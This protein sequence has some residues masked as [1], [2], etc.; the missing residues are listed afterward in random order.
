MI[1]K[2]DNQAIDYI[3]KNLEVSKE[4]KII[5]E[6]SKELRALVNG[7]NFIDELI[8]KIEGIESETKAKQEKNTAVIFKIYLSVYFNQFL[9]F[10]MLLWGLRNMI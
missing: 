8:C 4:F 10:I 2:D 7:E 1:F 6:N 5:R 9:I 3:K